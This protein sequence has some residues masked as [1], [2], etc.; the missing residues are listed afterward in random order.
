MIGLEERRVRLVLLIIPALVFCLGSASIAEAA[1]YAGAEACAQ[2]HE[3]VADDFNTTAH[4]R[5]GAHTWGDAASCESC[6][7]PGEAHVDSGGESGLLSPASMDA[8]E[9]NELCL[10]CHAGGSARHWKGSDHENL[11]VSCVSCH[12]MHT[13]WTNDKALSNKREIALCLSCHADMKKHLNQRSHHP[14]KEGAMACSDCHSPHG[15]PAEAAIAALSVNDKCYEC[16]MEK[17]GPFLWE[18][19]PVREDCTVCHDPHGS[20]QKNLLVKAAPRLCQSCHLLG[21]HQTVA[22]TPGQT[23]NINRSCLNCHLAIHGSNHPA[24]IVLMR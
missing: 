24:G 2:C 23:L 21:H 12:N 11:D 18:H 10:N 5:A 1:G 6:H 4:G 15:S 7:G 9:T 14:M 16:H 17:R 22:G 8:D 13:P 20:N 3:D 19:A